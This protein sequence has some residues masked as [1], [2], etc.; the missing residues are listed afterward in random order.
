MLTSGVV[1][2]CFR[3]SFDCPPDPTI[4]RYSAG[5]LDISTV[6]QIIVS[7]LLLTILRDFVT[8]ETLYWLEATTVLPPTLTPLLSVLM[9]SLG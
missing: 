5:T 9:Q 7:F 4:Y 2:S 1:D 3:C 6:H 8:R